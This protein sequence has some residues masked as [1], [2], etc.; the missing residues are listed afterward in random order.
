MR[1]VRKDRLMRRPYS[2]LS[3]PRG[4]RVPFSPVPPLVNPF[5]TGW[6]L[7]EHPGCGRDVA[8]TID[9]PHNSW[10]LY[11]FCHSSIHI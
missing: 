10:A 7:S 6:T 8:H 5:A 3:A 1:T 11:A 9:L 2:V 4:K